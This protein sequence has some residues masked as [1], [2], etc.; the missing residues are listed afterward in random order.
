MVTFCRRFALW[1]MRV[2]V[3]GMMDQY[4]RRLADKEMNG[5]AVQAS[6]ASNV[7][8]APLLLPITEP[9]P[10]QSEGTWRWLS[11]L[12]TSE[13]EKIFQWPKVSCCLFV[14]LISH[15]NTRYT[16][17]YCIGVYSKRYKHRQLCKTRYTTRPSN[18]F[19]RT[20]SSATKFQ[21][22]YDYGAFL[23]SI[24]ALSPSWAH[25]RPLL[26]SYV[27]SLSSFHC[28]TLGLLRASYFS[29]YALSARFFPTDMFVGYTSSWWPC[30]LVWTHGMMQLDVISK[31]MQLDGPV[32]MYSK[33]GS[34]SQKR[35]LKPTVPRN[36]SF[37]ARKIQKQHRVLI[38][39]TDKECA[40][41]ICGFRDCRWTLYTGTFS[42]T[43]N[44]TQM[45]SNTMCWLAFSSLIS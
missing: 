5:Y 17:G 11:A 38:Y 40:P 27:C 1:T 30:W 2:M 9:G 12:L 13:R 7:D 6:A 15:F 35:R 41:V 20:W 28:T 16:V 4:R 44:R 14:S 10:L 42:P 34:Q 39:F 21:A 18:L 45:V 36:G 26:N 25:C 3:H 23:S 32:N 19:S 31:N 33:Q 43:P 37:I 8:K 24:S 29:P 22:G